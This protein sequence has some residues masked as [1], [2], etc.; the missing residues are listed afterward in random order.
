MTYD[1]HRKEGEHSREYQTV[2]D[3]LTGTAAMH[4]PKKSRLSRSARGLKCVQEQVLVVVAL[5]APLTGREG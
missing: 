4:P 1:A 5:V 3:H 2:T